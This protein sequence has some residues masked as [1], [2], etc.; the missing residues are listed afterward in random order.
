MMK[1]ILVPPRLVPAACFALLL[2]AAPGLGADSLITRGATWNYL[3]NG[4]DQG[5]AW[6]EPDFDD[7]SWASGPGQLGYGDGDEATVVSFGPDPTSKFIT[8]YFRHA[9]DVADASAVSNL[10]LHVLR[11]DGVVVYLNGVEVFRNNMP[12]GPISFN[13]LA[14]GVVPDENAYVAAPIPTAQ[15]ASGR[16][17]IAAEVHQANVTS[18]DIGFDLALVADGG[19][20]P[21]P[22]PELPFVS[23]EAVDN[24]A[25]ESGA[26]PGL[27]RIR[28][29]GPTTE[30]LLVTLSYFGTAVNG[31]DCLLLPSMVEIPSGSSSVDLPVEVI[32]DSAVEG[33]ESFLLI[34]QEPPCVVLNP[35]EPG[36]YRVAAPG[37]AVVTILDDDSLPPPPPPP[38]GTVTLIGSNSVWKY[39]DNGTDQGT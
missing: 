13:T 10:V 8:T 30:G 23:V 37:Q 16:N 6:R 17:V 35:F 36:C 3:D 20:P 28:R 39:L 5:T 38:P 33:P 21:P 7:S 12:A 31:T 27:F 11:D 19:S 34:L 24:T 29:T 26:N 32:D 9:F 4:S 15:L 25:S 2:A 1:R 22:P 18:S 14:S